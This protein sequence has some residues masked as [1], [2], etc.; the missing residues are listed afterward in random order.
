MYRLTI[1]ARY[2]RHKLSMETGHYEI[3]FGFTIDL[4][5]IDRDELIDKLG[6]ISK[7]LLDKAVE[8]LEEGYKT[9]RLY[10]PKEYVLAITRLFNADSEAVISDNY[11]YVLVIEQKNGD[12]V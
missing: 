2:K 10:I 7:E 6:T 5:E 1:E 8:L 9:I 4:G 11:E 3:L 12:R